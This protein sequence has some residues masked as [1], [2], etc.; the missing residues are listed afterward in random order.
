MKALRGS[1]VEILGFFDNDSRREGGV[2]F[3]R[4]VSP[5]FLQRGRV[6]VLSQWEREIAQQLLKMGYS[7]EEI[8]LPT[9]QG[10]QGEKRE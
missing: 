9:L 10:T 4:R 8:L 2:F 5:P 3:N 6:L 1:N 7:E